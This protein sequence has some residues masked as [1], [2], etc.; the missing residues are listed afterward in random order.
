MLSADRSPVVAFYVQAPDWAGYRAQDA[1]GTWC[2]YQYKPV[3]RSTHWVRKNGRGE[4]W[5][6]A[7]GMPNP[8]WL[9]TCERVR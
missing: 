1:D 7:H 2:F 8:D 9:A 4:S 6:V 3:A 5:V